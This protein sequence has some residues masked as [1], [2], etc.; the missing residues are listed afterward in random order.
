MLFSD[1]TATVRHYNDGT[2]IVYD[3]VSQEGQT[4]KA[5]SY[6]FG[7]ESQ[8]GYGQF[9]ALYDGSVLYTAVIDAHTDV[10]GL[11]NSTT[12][13]AIGYEYDA[14]GNELSAATATIYNPFRYT[15]QYYDTETGLY[16]LRARYY[17]PTT[18]TFTQRDSYLG[19]E[20]NPLTLNLYLYCLGNPV[21]NVDLSGRG[22]LSIIIDVLLLAASFTPWS[23]MIRFTVISVYVIRF[24]MAVADLISANKILKKNVRNTNA[25]YQKASAILTMV[26]CV[27][28]VIATMAGLPKGAIAKTL[29][30]TVINAVCSVWGTAVSVT[31]LLADVCYMATT[32]RNPSRRKSY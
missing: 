3:E 5:N 12:G 22:A 4:G 23:Y 19:E 17:D 16:Y 31:L 29:G 9:E 15:S 21:M 13:T 11:V 27:I 6:V 10:T 18:G 20:R 1:N 25:S 32:G 14:Y 8:D 2:S 26:M 28:G 30:R 24:G 7:A